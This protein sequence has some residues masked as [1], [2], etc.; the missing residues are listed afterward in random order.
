MPK[1]GS[2]C[3]SHRQH[4]KIALMFAQGW[5]FNAERSTKHSAYLEKDG[6]LKHVGTFGIAITVDIENPAPFT[7]EKITL[8][9]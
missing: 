4:N 7:V 2:T 3:Y 8:T 9:K 6:V 1:F 5:T